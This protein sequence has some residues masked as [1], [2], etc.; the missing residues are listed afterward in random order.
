MHSFEQFFRLLASGSFVARAQSASDA[1]ADVLVENLEREGLERRVDRRDL[2]E[3]VDAVAVLFDHAL[4]AP[5]LALDPVQASDE[6]I[7]VFRVAVGVLSLGGAHHAPFS[8]ALEKR[9]DACEAELRLNRRLCHDVYLD[10][11][12]IWLDG[13]TP[14]MGER[15]A[16]VDYGVVKMNVDTDTQYAFTRPVAAHMFSNYDGVLKVDG[17]VG[18]KK[19]YDPRAWGKAAEAGI[20]TAPVVVD[21]WRDMAPGIEYQQNVMAKPLPAGMQHHMAFTFQRKSASFGESDDQGVTVASQLATPAQGNAV[22]LYG[23][24]DTHVGILRN[25]EVSKLL[26]ELLAKSF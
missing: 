22:R 17:E 15:G 21:V 4:D 5:H 2:R 3:D 18:N 7:L 14:R 26:N 12:P 1:V 24:D 16:A 10:V 9:R 11:R 23:F 6:G 8:R 13:P 19:A 25:P 20:R